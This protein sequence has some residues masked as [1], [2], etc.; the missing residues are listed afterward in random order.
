MTT[1]YGPMAHFVA[2]ASANVFVNPIEIVM[3][4]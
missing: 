1:G 4:L 3:L 2:S